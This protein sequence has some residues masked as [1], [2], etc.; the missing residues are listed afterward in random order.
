[1]FPEGADLCKGIYGSAQ[2]PALSVD[3]TGTTF[4]NVPQLDDEQKERFP[5]LAEHG[6]LEELV[7]LNVSDVS[8][9]YCNCIMRELGDSAR[10]CSP[11]QLMMLDVHSFTSS[12]R[13]RARR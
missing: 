11:L 4:F 6:R 1:L 9:P 7:L 12:S 10:S 2:V 13:T 8:T 3:A 5:L